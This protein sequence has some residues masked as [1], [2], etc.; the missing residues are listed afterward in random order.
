MRGIGQFLALVGAL[1]TFEA[2]AQAVLRDLPGS[3]QP[4][5][6]RP[7]P[8]AAPSRDFEFSIDA[9]RRAPVPR[10]VDELTFEVHDVR[11]TGATAFS[12]QE[13]RGIA[14]P[15][16]GNRATLSDILAVAE[17]IE[18][19][20]LAAGYILSRAFV[21]RQ[22]ISEGVFQITVVEG[23]VK[24]VAVEGGDEATRNRILRLLDPVKRVRPLD[25]P[26]LERALLVGND[27]P[28]VSASALVRPSPD[29]PG[30]ADLVVTLAQAPF[31][32][33]AN[34]DNRGSKFTGRWNLS[35]DTA[36]NS[37]FGFGEQIVLGAATTGDFEEK[38][39]FQARLAQP[40]GSD[41]LVGTLGALVTKGKPGAGLAAFDIVTD[42]FAASTRLSYPV[43]RSRGFTLVLDGGFTWQDAKVDALDVGISRD[44]WRVADV[45]ASVSETGFLAGATSA[46]L[47]LAK[48]LEILGASP[49]ESAEIS[50]ALG[51]TD[52]TK[53][54]ATVRRTQL[55]EGGFSAGL[56]ALGQYSFD[57]LIA[58][59]EVSFGGS[60]IGRGYDPGAIAG[61]HGIGAAL[62][63]RYDE[64][65]TEIWLEAAQPY[66]FFDAA[67]TWSRE[68]TRPGDSLRSAGLGVRLGFVA[69]LSGTLEVARTLTGVP[70]SNGGALDT[71]FYVGAGFR[72]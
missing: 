35:A 42:S 68:P 25:R 67:R 49:S 61:D 30:A 17:T 34:A 36:L 23:Y 40:I 32:I 46:T 50:R 70:G 38:R 48:G 57:S 18:A 15:L 6:D 1:A 26:T 37:L 13:L 9:P 3:V 39:A 44:H 63:L 31:N 4:G 65:F 33:V 10:T 11:I 7:I 59:E 56:T 12:E 2:A 53:L 19:R 24:E 21:P 16:V 71:R 28:G 52:F 43:Y 54:T 64:R 45:S 66:L 20:Y 8:D 41:G 47:G 60:N 5:R 55:I 27:L 29:E 72:F 62:E 58:G 22:R 69:G 14:E 51:R